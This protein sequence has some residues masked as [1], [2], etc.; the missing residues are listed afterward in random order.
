[1][2]SASATTS[3]AA[4]RV[5]IARTLAALRALADGRCGAR[6]PRL[7]A[8][9]VLMRST[10]DGFAALTDEL[11]AAGID[12][13]SYNL[14]GGRDRPG[15]YAAEAVPPAALDRLLQQLPQLRLRLADVGVTLIGSDDYATRL[16]AASHGQRWPVDDCAPGTRFLFVDEHGRIA[17]CA[18][19]GVEYGI[20]LDDIDGLDELPSR[21]AAARRARCSAAC[22]DCPSTQVFGKFDPPAGVVDLAFED[23]SADAG[24]CA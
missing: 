12:E 11:A 23:V 4:G 21:F 15:F 7:R 17:P 6:T 16:R 13:I 24:E 3:C 9:I 8:N 18:F 1:M 20:A 14:L 2:R 10:I 19:T 22:S 5:A